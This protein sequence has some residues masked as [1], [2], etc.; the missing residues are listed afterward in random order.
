MQNSYLS[1]FP[2]WIR[3]TC[4]KEFHM[5]SEIMD[6]VATDHMGLRQFCMCLIQVE[7]YQVSPWR[8]WY[9]CLAFV[10]FASLIFPTAHAARPG[11][12]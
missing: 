7:K 6:T 2:L 11:L 1:S 12:G 4:I 8:V 3:I 10:T 9:H 5:L